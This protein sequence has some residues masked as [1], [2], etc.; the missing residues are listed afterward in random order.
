MIVLGILI[1][2]TAMSLPFWLGLGGALAGALI[3]L[4]I[5]T[6]GLLIK[7]GRR[8]LARSATQV[9]RDDPR[10][11]V[12]Y[13]RPFKGDGT[14]MAL[15]LLKSRRKLELPPGWRTYEQKL[16]RAVRA[17]GPLVAVGNPSEGRPQLGAARHYVPDPEWQST[18]SRLIEDS[19]LI[20]LHV[21]DSDGV[22]WELSRVV[23]T[24]NPGKL[25]ISLPTDEKTGESIALAK[26]NRF[27]ELS[28]SAR[29]FPKTLPEATPDGQFLYFGADWTPHI[30]VPKRESEPAISLG[31]TSALGRAQTLG[32][33]GLHGEFLRVN[34]P[35]WIRLLFVLVG[36]PVLLVALLFMMLSG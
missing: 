7:H 12:L 28:T 4:A 33:Q 10:R 13:L 27:R 24:V 14:V 19:Q 6:G 32:L 20:I 15:S 18:I 17:I 29:I 23:E 31:E 22:L 3:G 30:L 34:S 16:A 26:Y 35:Y 5:G 11:P 9:R 8:M 36:I 1:P 25:I 21:G 2:L